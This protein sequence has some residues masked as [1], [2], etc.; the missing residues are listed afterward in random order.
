LTGGGRIIKNHAFGTKV[1]SKFGRIFT[2]VLP[3][4]LIFRYYF[5][6]AGLWQEK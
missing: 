6:P 4:A 3:S 2:L 5:E 1:K